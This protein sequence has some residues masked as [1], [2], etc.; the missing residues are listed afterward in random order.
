MT[1][2]S[3]FSVSRDEWRCNFGGR[4][5]L[6]RPLK[7][8]QN[9]W[10]F[11]FCN[12][13][14]YENFLAGGRWKF[15]K[16]VFWGRVIW[17]TPNSKPIVNGIALSSSVTRKGC[18]SPAWPATDTASKLTGTGWHK[19]YRSATPNTTFSTFHATTFNVNRQQQHS[20]SHRH[21]QI[22]EIKTFVDKTIG[23]TQNTSCCSRRCIIIIFFKPKN[24]RRWNKK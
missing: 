3:W 1:N 9:C 12:D 4:W 20:G 7:H 18:P 10:N 17:M 6:E 2:F 16:L 21:Q 15:Q 22:T 13:F 23:F 5:E 14:P 8:F 11:V 19:T 24:T